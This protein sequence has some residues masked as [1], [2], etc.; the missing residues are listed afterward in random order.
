ML[1]FFPSKLVIEMKLT[2]LN[3]IQNPVPQSNWPSHEDTSNSDLPKR[4]CAIGLSC[5]AIQF[6]DGADAVVGSVLRLLEAKPKL[7][8]FV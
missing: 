8:A 5:V 2:L 3:G 4:A 1:N 7:A 6:G